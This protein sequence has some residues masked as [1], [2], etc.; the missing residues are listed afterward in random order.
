M[1]Y[2]L[3]MMTVL[4][5]ADSKS[6]AHNRGSSQFAGLPHLRI[7]SLVWFVQ[8]LISLNGGGVLIPAP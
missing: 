6:T 7:W 4:Q 3:A 1:L 8:T 5:D 2:P